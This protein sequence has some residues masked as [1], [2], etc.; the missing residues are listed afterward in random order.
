MKNAD[1]RIFTCKNRCRYS[2]KRATFCR[3]F[4]ERAAGNRTR[5]EAFWAAA[6]D[7]HLRGRL[8]SF[9]WRCHWL[10]FLLRSWMRIQLCVIG[11]W[12]LC[13]NQISGRG[14][15]VKIQQTLRGSFSAVSKPNFAI[16][17]SLESSRRDLQDLPTSAP[18]GY[19]QLA[20][21]CR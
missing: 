7:L 9:H 18:L 2:R 4:A 3:N 12:Y 21:F 16:K 17:Y 5:R 19:Q 20:N 1:K 10:R 14:N 8:R 13:E 15:Y 11:A 6:V